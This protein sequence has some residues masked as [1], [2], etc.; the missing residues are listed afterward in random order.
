MSE[1]AGDNGPKSC[2]DFLDG[3]I[4]EICGLSPDT[5]ITEEFLEGMLD[6]VDLNATSFDPGYQRRHP[7][8]PLLTHKEA[9]EQRERV[10]T[11]RL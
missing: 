3:K 4:R 10:R 5:P 11:A 8:M 1:V 6:E 7:G 2:S 9:S